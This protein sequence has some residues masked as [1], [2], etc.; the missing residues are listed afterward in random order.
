[1]RGIDVVESHWSIRLDGG[2]ARKPLRVKP[3]PERWMRPSPQRV[4]GHRIDGI[5]DL[6]LLV[7]RELVD[8]PGVHVAKDVGEY[9]AFQL[10]DHGPPRLV[11]ARHAR[12]RCVMPSSR[13]LWR[14]RHEL[15]SPPP[16]C[17]ENYR[18]TGSTT[19]RARCSPSN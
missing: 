10:V 13:Q 5:I 8:A 11:T 17:I 3:L 18:L 2:A 9:R 14:S 12:A 15:V 7:S 1:M 6:E 19:W 16:H 4:T